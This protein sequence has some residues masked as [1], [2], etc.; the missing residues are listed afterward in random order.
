MSQ[1]LSNVTIHIV[2]STKNRRN[3]L[4][5][6]AQIELY[7]YMA[8]ILISKNCHNCKIGGTEN[9]IH[10]LC[11]LPRTI[12][13]SELIE[14]IKTNSS[15]WLKK[16]SHD[17]SN[18]QWQNGFGVFSVSPSHLNIINQYIENQEEHHKK[19]TFEDELIKLLTKYKI[20]YDERYLFN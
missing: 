8:Q 10:I 13:I 6:E 12:S 2:F 19:I 7:S 9:H 16:K 11:Q 20:K 1:S 17:L 15:K 4:I 18:F 14:E 5:K 3:L